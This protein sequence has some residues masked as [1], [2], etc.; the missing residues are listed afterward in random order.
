MPMGG[1][2]N[3]VS[4]A[5]LCAA[6]G[7]P[8]HAIT[9][10]LAVKCRQTA[11]KMA[12]P[13]PVGSKHG[14][15][16]KER[17]LFGYCIAH[18]GQ[19]PEPKDQDDHSSKHSAL[20]TSTEAMAPVQRL[21]LKGAALQR[22]TTCMAKAIYF[23]AR[24]EP[25]RGQIAVAQVVMNRVFSGHYPQDVCGVV[26]QNADQF[27]SCQF[28]FACDGTSTSTIDDTRAWRLANIIAVK[29][30]DGDLYEQ[31]VGASTH[32]HANYVHPTWVHEMQKNVTLGSQSFYRPTAWGAKGP[33]WSAA[34][35]PP[36]KAAKK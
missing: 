22:A 33:R 4:L 15:A 21:H 9:A 30:L 16:A 11:F 5:I 34:K 23:E 1:W 14:N 27:N 24:G 29:M 8:A 18:D 7:S 31:D 32:Y 26:Y 36:K 20:N 35:T 28:T 19:M 10:A 6:F 2:K 3:P 13:R 17:Q 12:P 25:I